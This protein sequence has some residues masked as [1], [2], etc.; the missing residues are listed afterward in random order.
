MSNL[1][2][3]K[4][5]RSPA[6]AELRAKGQVFGRDGEILARNKNFEE[7]YSI[8]DHLKEKG[9]SYQWN[10]MTYYGKDDVPEMT[11]MMDNGWRYVKPDSDI[12][13]S[14]G[15]TTGDK[16]YIEIG[17]L[18]LMERPQS[19]TDEALEESRMRT[20]AQYDSLMGK[21]N[22]LSV[23]DGFRKFPK[24]VARGARERIP[25]DMKPKLNPAVDIPDD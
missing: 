16:D 25:S 17:G 12:G 14:Y 6:R 15:M 2:T 18:V 5:G 21:S 4:P 19:L 11:R 10:R 23:P 20:A 9:W 24:R 13:K 3:A 22:D 8:P 7:T 1:S